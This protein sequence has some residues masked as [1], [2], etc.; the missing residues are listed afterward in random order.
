MSQIATFEKTSQ[1]KM[2]VTDIETDPRIAQFQVKNPIKMH[3]HV[4]YLV[5]GVDS[6][7]PFEDSRRFKEFFSLRK[8]LVER[9]PGI[10]IPAIPEK[11]FMSV[12]VNKDPRKWAVQDNFDAKFVVERTLLLEKFI[13]EIAKYEFLVES[14]EFKLFSRGQGEIEKQLQNLP[15][16]RPTQILEKYRL[17]FK[18]DEEQKAETASYIEK[19]NV[20]MNFLKKSITVMRQQK[21]QLKS[22][23]VTRSKEMES[24]P[25]IFDQFMKFENFSMEYLADGGAGTRT[26]THPNAGDGDFPTAVRNLSMQMINPYVEAYVWFKNELYTAE[27]MLDALK[28]VEAVQKACINCEKKKQSD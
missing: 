25:K 9:W 17:N 12:E 15:G 23:K 26:F 18:I 16:Q 14:K 27:S 8:C 24:Y 4:R 20:F 11:K 2:P 13:K 21:K 6:Q 19:I 1:E 22:L 28:G 3:G 7:G 10:Y 5:C